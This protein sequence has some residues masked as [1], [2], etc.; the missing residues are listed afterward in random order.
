LKKFKLNW[1]QPFQKKKKKGKKK[2]TRKSKRLW[3]ISRKL[4]LSGQ[5]REPTS[6]NTF[7]GQIVPTTVLKSKT[8]W[9]EVAPHFS[10][11]SPA[12]FVEHKESETLSAA[13]IEFE[14]KQ[15]APVTA[16]YW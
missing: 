16:A 7:E 5:Q 9:Y 10:E 6:A 11:E 1:P 14:H 3:S 8:F 12:Q 13:F 2:I 15:L 4:A